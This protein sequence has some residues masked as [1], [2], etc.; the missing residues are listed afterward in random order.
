[1]GNLTDLT[2]LNLKEI[3]LTGAV[4]P[5]TGNLSKLEGMHLITN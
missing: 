4:P 5:Q 2:S 3:Y 1:L